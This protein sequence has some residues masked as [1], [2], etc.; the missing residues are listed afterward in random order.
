MSTRVRAAPFS[1][2]EIPWASINQV[3]IK[4][5]ITHNNFRHCRVHFYAFVKATFLEAAV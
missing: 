1:N 2:A 3:L 4:T 5:T